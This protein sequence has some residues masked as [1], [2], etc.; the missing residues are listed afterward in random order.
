M[1]TEVRASCNASSNKNCASIV[2]WATASLAA[3]WNI[4]SAALCTKRSDHRSKTE[5]APCVLLDEADLVIPCSLRGAERERERERE[6]ND[7]EDQKQY[8]H[9]THCEVIQPTLSIAIVKRSRT[10]HCLPLNALMALSTATRLA[11]SWYC[12]RL[13]KITTTAPRTTSLSHSTPKQSKASVNRLI[14]ITTEL[15]L[16]FVPLLCLEQNH[17]TNKFE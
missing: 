2:D 9:K 5:L 17:D 10:G 14:V 13:A 4:N 6:Y 1:R 3:F 11:R 8:Q 12:C 15:P 7:N 16:A